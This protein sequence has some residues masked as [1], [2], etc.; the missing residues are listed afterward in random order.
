VLPPK[1]GVHD[2]ALPPVTLQ[3]LE[4][5]EVDA[6]ASADPI[7]WRGMRALHFMI[8]SFLLAHP[9]CG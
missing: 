1:N 8:A 2:P 5:R 9:T 6:P 3:A 4:V 7:L